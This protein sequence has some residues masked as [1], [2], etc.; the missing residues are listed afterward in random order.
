MAKKL[1]VAGCSYSDRIQVDVCYGDILSTRLGTEYLHEARTCGSNYRIWR[2]IFEKV[3]NGEISQ[4]DIVLIQY[5]EITR[6][7]LATWIDPLAKAE[8][9]EKFD[10]E[11][12][13][14]RF[15]MDANE[16]CFDNDAKQ[17]LKSY[18][19]RWVCIPYEEQRFRMNNHMFQCMLEHHRI[20]TFF[21]NLSAYAPN[22]NI[23]ST[24]SYFPDRVYV[25]NTLHLPPYNI[26]PDDKWHLS[27]VGH[28]KVADDVYEFIKD[29]I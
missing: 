10:P 13:L 20:N 16:L 21:L 15:K 18:I 28:K 5:T 11:T 23:W 1:V 8:L 26:S 19:D 27:P 6:D 17:W 29:R 14:F 2:R 24:I 7:E 25:D 9:T 4:D 3:T 22:S 12:W